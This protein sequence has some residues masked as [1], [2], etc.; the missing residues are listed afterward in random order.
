MAEIHTQRP[1]IDPIQERMFWLELDG[2]MDV[3]FMSFSEIAEEISISKYR[4]GNGPNYVYKQR[5]MKSYGEVTLERGIFTG[6][7][8]IAQWQESGERKTVSIVRLDHLGEEVKRYTLYDAF[9]VKYA[10]GGGD[11]M[12]EDGVAV[13]VLDIAFD[14][15]E[16]ITESTPVT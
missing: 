11:A 6:E 12:S 5:G 3:G 14:Y 1:G 2:S 9:P 4:E 15:A 16:F 8:V 13:Q 7:D 10:T